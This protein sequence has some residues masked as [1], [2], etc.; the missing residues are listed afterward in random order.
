MLFILVMEALSKMM[1][2]AVSRGLIKGFDASLSG[3][4][5]VTVTHICY[6][7][8]MRWSFVMQRC[9]R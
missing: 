1:D 9:L 5:K 7:Q 8:M 2:R 4:S 6:L 3:H